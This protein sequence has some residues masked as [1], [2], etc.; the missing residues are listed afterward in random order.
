MEEKSFTQKEV[1]DIVKDRLSREKDKFAK[2]LGIG[3]DFDKSKYA[4]FKKYLDTQ[5]TEAEKTQEELA[6]WQTKYATL[7]KQVQ[8]T[9]LESNMKNILSELDVEHSKI[10][11]IKK[12]IDTNDLFN[13]D[14]FN[15]NEIKTRISKIIDEQLTELKKTQKVGIEKEEKQPEMPA[16]NV[17]IEAFKKM[18]GYN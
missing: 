13:E 11:V 10:S 8:D 2:D 4:E 3:E 9:T 5:K 17:Y 15:N 1:D 12:L 6:N 7:E 16:S 18:K 14:G